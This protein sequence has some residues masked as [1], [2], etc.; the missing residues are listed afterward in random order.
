MESSLLSTT[1]SHKP[2]GVRSALHKKTVGGWHVRELSQKPQDA[3]S[4]H[5]MQTGICLWTTEDTNAHD[6]FDR[7]AVATLAAM[8]SFGD[9]ATLK[10]PLFE[11]YAF[12]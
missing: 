7:F 12:V 1:N 8:A 5:L 3:R 4:D 11:G 10:R 6:V 9:N 2:G